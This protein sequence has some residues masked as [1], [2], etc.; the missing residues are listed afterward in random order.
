MR[1][2]QKFLPRNWFK[3]IVCLAIIPIN[4]VEQQFTILN[5]ISSFQN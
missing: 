1:E 5:D 4:H 2:A 3:D